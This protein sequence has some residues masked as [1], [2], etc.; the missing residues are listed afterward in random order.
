MTYGS[1]RLGKSLWAARIPSFNAV[2]PPPRVNIAPPKA[3]SNIL[4]YNDPQVVEAI[5][6]VQAFGY[7]SPSPRSCSLLIT[8]PEENRELAAILVTLAANFC[9]VDSPDIRT[10]MDFERRILRGAIPAAILIPIAKD[11]RG[12]DG[13]V[14]GLRNTFNVRRTDVSPAEMSK[15]TAWLQIGN[16][17]PFASR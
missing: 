15:F 8:A 10:D 5:N 14:T 9:N 13:L 7:L 1:Y 11:T 6:T 3:Q 2:F 12:G 17:S 4:S 16:G